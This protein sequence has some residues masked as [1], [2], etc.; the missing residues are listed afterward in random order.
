[1][2]SALLTLYFILFVY[3]S[4]K[5]LP[6]VISKLDQLRKQASTTETNSAEDLLESINSDDDEP[7]FSLLSDNSNNDGNAKSEDDNTLHFENEDNNMNDNS[8]LGDLG[9]IGSE[10]NKTEGSGIDVEIL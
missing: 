3:P 7:R 9:S 5:E 6:A 10:N 2:N 4:I 8:L 1:M